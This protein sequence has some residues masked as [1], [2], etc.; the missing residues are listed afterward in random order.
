MNIFVFKNLIDEKYSHP[1]M[2]IIHAYEIW[3]ILYLYGHVKVPYFF[4]KIKKG[5]TLV[6]KL[7]QIPKWTSLTYIQSR[8][9]ESTFEHYIY[10][11]ILI[12]PV[13]S[14]IIMYFYGVYLRAVLR[15]KRA[16]PIITRIGQNL[17]RPNL[18][19]QCLLQ[20]Y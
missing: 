2:S 3:E 17:I 16:R 5:E 15:E 14:T 10:R 11:G 9:T 7:L 8:P 6:G 13:L 4:L 12:N 1:I 20:G 18:I 19:P